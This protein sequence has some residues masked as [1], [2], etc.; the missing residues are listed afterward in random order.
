MFGFIITTHFNN[1]ETIIK[2]L[3]LLLIT[4]PDK[5]VI[6]LYVNETTDE[7]VK[8]I[9]NE[10][11][12]INSNIINI[13]YENEDNIILKTNKIIFEVF[14][15]DDQ[16]KNNGLTGTWNDG[17]KYI[18][19][20]YLEVKIITILGHDTFVNPT[21]NYIFKKAISAVI[22]NKL[23]YYGP[24][25]KNWNGKNDEL[26]Q[27]E[28]H[29]KNYDEKFLIGSLL[30][31]P[32]YCL[33]K[34]MLPNG[35]FFDNNYPFGYNDIDWY[36]RF[37]KI[38]GKAVIVEKCI[39]DH[40]YNRSWIPYDPRLNSKLKLENNSNLTNYSINELYCKYSN[41]NFKNFNW[42]EYSNKNIHLKFSTKVQAF[43]HYMSK[44]RYN[45]R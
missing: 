16:I 39:I 2:S 17:I 37:K 3:N 36:N 41:I 13:D 35:N 34:N 28:K 8:N 10:F 7:K 12:S 21:I 14:Y 24:L 22:N 26:W 15:I 18:I 40:K 9:K 20:N 42:N 44:G 43:N 33:V 1:Y 6:L 11:T 27:D 29:Y 38:G 4:I 45:L 32:L 30:C 31:I 23:E 19:K 25:Y 5:S